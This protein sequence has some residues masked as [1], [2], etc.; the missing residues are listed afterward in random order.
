MWVGR[1]A[2]NAGIVLDPAVGRI[3]TGASYVVRH[4]LAREVRQRPV[5][6]AEGAVR[7]V[8]NLEATRALRSAVVMDRDQYV[9]VNTVCHIDAGLDL[10]APVLVR[11]CRER[12]ERVV[13]PAGQVHV[14]SGGAEK[15][16]EAS[17]DVHIDVF[18]REIAVS[19]PG[20]EAAVAGINKDGVRG[21]VKE[22]GYGPVR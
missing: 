21:R 18:L 17:S 5:V 13:A 15:R 10:I 22:L 8:V 11:V 12:R 20:V 4:T 14:V 7:V 2:A 16:R 19:G 9:R 3:V 1:V 6:L